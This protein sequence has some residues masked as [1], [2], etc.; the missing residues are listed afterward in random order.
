MARRRRAEP[1]TPEARQIALA[2]RQGERLG[3]TQREIADTLGI[4]PR[5]VRKVKSGQTSGTRTY[6]RVMKTPKT[7]RVET[8]LFNAE[9]VVGFTAS[10]EPVIAST[11]VTI[12]SLT[13]AGGGRRAP[14][15]LDVFRVRGLAS[16]V[17]AER[18]KQIRRYAAVTTPAGAD[19][20]V[21]LRAINRARRATTVIRTVA[22]P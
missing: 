1:T 13:V 12:P 2:I 16:V 15:P 10:D 5:T 19:S 22:A 7:R 21:R 18:A 4:D 17:A 20:P 3:L 8:G 9:F 11:N 6:G 14:T